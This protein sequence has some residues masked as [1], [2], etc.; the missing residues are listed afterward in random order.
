[1]PRLPLAALV[2][3]ALTQVFS[4]LPATAG[5][6]P[7]PSIMPYLEERDDYNGPMPLR[8]RNGGQIRGHVMNVD[9]RSGM[10]TVQ[11]RNGRILDIL[12]LP[13]TNISG[14]SGFQT[15]ADIARGAQVHVIMSRRG[16]SFIAQL[17]TIR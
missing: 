2:L 9:Y 1:M 3:V 12:V 11:A 10:M 6:R 16:N 7:L 5:P 17:I 15:I 14:R 8:Q 13:S 4:A